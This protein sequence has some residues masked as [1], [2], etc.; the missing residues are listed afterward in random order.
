M[1]RVAR[2]AHRL[3]SELEIDVKAIEM[4]VTSHARG[5]IR[6]EIEGDNGSYADI[7]YGTLERRGGRVRV[8]VKTFHASATVEVSA[9]NLHTPDIS[10]TWI[11]ENIS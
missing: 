10:N 8:A 9:Q 6:S 5:A 11:L 4:S 7:K 3:P 1:T 2:V